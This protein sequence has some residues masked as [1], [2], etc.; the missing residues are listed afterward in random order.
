MIDP[1]DTIAIALAC[2]PLAGALTNRAVARLAEA[3]EAQHSVNAL[4]VE[5]IEWL[6]AQLEDTRRALWAAR[7]VT[8]EEGA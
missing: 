7:P 8:R 3:V 6:E 4:H 5:R 2:A 1:T